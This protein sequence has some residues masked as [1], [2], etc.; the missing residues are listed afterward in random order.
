MPPAGNG[1]QYGHDY[2][3]LSALKALT[4]AEPGSSLLLVHHTR[5]AGSEDFLDAVSG[6]QGIAGAADTILL[7]RRDRHDARAILQVTSRDAAE[8]EYSLKLTET[9]AWE[10]DG[11]TLAEAAHAAQTAKAS[12]GVG[13]RMAE[14]IETVARF[15]EGIKPH[16]VAVVLHLDTKTAQVYLSR[17]HEAGR[18]RRPTRGVYAPVGSVGLLVSS[19]AQYQ[20][21][22]TN[23][24]PLLEGETTR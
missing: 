2:A 3:V 11:D 19:P 4:D 24:T 21:T 17:A 9:S 22:N 7:L 10:L 8:G 15:P 6:T 12:E 5:K 13:D 20:H 1:N 14:V 18:I 16:D 23:N